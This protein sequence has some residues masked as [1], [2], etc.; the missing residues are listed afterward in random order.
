MLLR[1]TTN[2]LIA[3]VTPLVVAQSDTSQPSAGGGVTLPSLGGWSCSALS[4]SNR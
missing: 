2:D 3:S 4:G 1:A